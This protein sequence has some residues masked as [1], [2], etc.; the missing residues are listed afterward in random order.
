[1]GFFCDDTFANGDAVTAA[2]GV[3]GALL[4]SDTVNIT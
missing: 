3:D 4:A 2:Q 1:M